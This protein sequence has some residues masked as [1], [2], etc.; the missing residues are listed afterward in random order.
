MAFTQIT[1]SA[2]GLGFECPRVVA[3][4][5]GKVLSMESWAVRVLRDL[6]A[7]LVPY[8]SK[9]SPWPS[10]RAPCKISAPRPTEL[11]SAGRQGPRGI[12]VCVKV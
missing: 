12:P 10:G 11:E 6:G 2:A 4:V 5:A 3:S 9:C 1:F 8:L 7:D